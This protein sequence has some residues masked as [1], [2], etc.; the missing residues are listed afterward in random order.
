[1]GTNEI[2]KSAYGEGLFDNPEQLEKEQYGFMDDENE[3]PESRLRQEQLSDEERKTVVK[4]RSLLKA[5]REGT[6]Q[7]PDALKEKVIRYLEK[8]Q[9]KLSAREHEELY[10]LALPKDLYADLTHGKDDILEEDILEESD[11]P[12]EYRSFKINSTT[13]VVDGKVVKI[14]GK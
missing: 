1:M 4:I 5:D 6:K 11:I 9:D 8:I 3:G 10:N 7:V 13:E 14:G 12:K 2:I